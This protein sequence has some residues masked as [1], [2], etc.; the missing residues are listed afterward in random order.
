V[1]ATR[2]SSPV[3]DGSWVRVERP[4]P[5]KAGRVVPRWQDADAARYQI[6]TSAGGATWRTAATVAD[7]NGGRET[8]RLDSPADTRFLRMRGVRRATTYGYSLF[9]LEAHSITGR[10]PGADAP[11]SHPTARR[12][13]PGADTRK[14]GSQADMPSIRARASSAPKGC[15]Y[16]NQRGSLCPVPMIR[17]ARP[18][19]GAG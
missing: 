3:A 16:G 14:P 1:G 15:R 7:G 5:A 8:I 9:I 11:G 18:D 17:Q 2:W 4:A 10:P 6:L 19:G 13:H 12:R